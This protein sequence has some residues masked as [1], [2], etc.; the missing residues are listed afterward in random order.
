VLMLLANSHAPA[1]CRRAI[2]SAGGGR[3]C[4]SGQPAALHSTSLNG[5]PHRLAKIPLCSSPPSR[6]MAGCP[7]R[8]ATRTRG[9][10]AHRRELPREA[11]ERAILVSWLMFRGLSA[12]RGIALILFSF[13]FFDERHAPTPRHHHH[14]P[15]GRKRK[16]VQFTRSIYAQLNSALRK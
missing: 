15:A 1:A 13:F 11:R 2:E 7:I 3:L 4:E 8:F 14:C 16:T 12:S 6:G 9:E 10:L 5:D